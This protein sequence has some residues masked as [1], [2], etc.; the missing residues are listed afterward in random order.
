MKTN[1][2]IL[3]K[4]IEEISKDECVTEKYLAYK[5]KLSERQIR[6]YIKILKDANIIRCVGS[7]I[8]RKWEII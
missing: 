8:N 7:G 6:R 2:D 5:F 3:I 1:S 4:I